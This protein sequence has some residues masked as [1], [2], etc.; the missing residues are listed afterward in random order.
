MTMTY[1]WQTA[2][3][4][5]V[6]DPEELLKIL[7]LD[8]K[9]LPAAQAASALF[10]LKVPRGFINRIEKGNPDDPL[11]RQ[12]LPLHAECL[13]E[14]G[15]DVDP[16]NEKSVNPI[17]GLLHKYHGRVLLTLAGTCGINC[18][19]CFRRHFPYT[20]NNP[21]VAGWD[22]IMAYIERDASITEIILS[23]G[24]PLILNDHSLQAFT[25]L[26][27]DLPQI[28]RLRIHSRIPIVLPERITP[29]FLA[30]LNQLHIKPILVTHCN[31]PREIDPTV[32]QA[33][34]AL[35]KS[36]AV[37][38]NQA[39]LLKG[40]NDNVETLIALS[41]ALFD[42]GIQPY[43]LHLLDKTAGTAHF[44][45]DQQTA[46]QLHQELSA[47][48]SGYLVPKLVYEKPGAEGKIL[49]GSGSFC[50]D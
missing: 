16:L 3:V 18:R 32:K 34:V 25:D 29:T 9:L 49:L 4:D 31:H 23:G 30:W 37:L 40:I 19:F 33:F 46:F 45:C 7:G 14:P 26:L 42:I 28:K 8:L 17:P 21:G 1:A 36:S 38:L 24:D 50:T 13:T 5:V 22:K 44:D 12:I 43:Y 35:Q 41:E 20:E 27:T 39:V 15:Y 6:T 11:L 47:R 10:P 48:L 2:L